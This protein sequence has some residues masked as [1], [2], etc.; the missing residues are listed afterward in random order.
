MST[1]DGTKVAAAI[2][3]VEA[4]KHM[5]G[6]NPAIQ[7]S[8]QFNMTEELLTRYQAMLHLLSELEKQDIT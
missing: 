1:S 3:A 4:V 5:L 2:F 8:T 6:V 7:K